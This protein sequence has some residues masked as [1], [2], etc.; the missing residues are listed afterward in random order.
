M[1]ILTERELKE[2]LHSLISN[3]E[4]IDFC[5]DFDEAVIFEAIEDQNMRCGRAD[6]IKQAITFNQIEEALS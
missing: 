2:A 6:K 5:D 1:I 3:S 4:E